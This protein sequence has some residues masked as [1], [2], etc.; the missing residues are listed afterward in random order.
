MKSE[1]VSMSADDPDVTSSAVNAG[2]LLNL[3]RFEGVDPSDP[4]GTLPPDA[5]QNGIVCIIGIWPAFPVDT[6]I[7]RVEIFI[8][9]NPKFVAWAEY[10]AA[11]NAPEFHIPI[12]PLSLPNLATFEVYYTVRSINLTTSPSRRLTFAITPPPQ[13]LEESTFPDADLWGY[14]G[15]TKNNPLD[16]DALFIWEGIRTLIPFNDLFRVGDVISLS[17]Q[18][19]RSLNGTGAALTPLYT[20]TAAVTDVANKKPVLIVIRPFATHI[21]PM[22]ENDSATT[23]YLLVRNGVSIFSS[24]TGLVKIDRVIPGTPGFCSSARWMT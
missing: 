17:W 15:C 6:R 4:A 3:P 9:G 2:I 13:L 24:F 11:D 22:R 10:S 14:I 21:E 5:K 8:V 7:D 18:G 16:P 1:T 20:F 12:A 23:E 19:W